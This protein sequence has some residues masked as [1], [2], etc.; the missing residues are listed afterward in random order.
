MF[1]AWGRLLATNARLV[2]IVAILTLVAAVTAMVTVAPNLSS[3]GF[4]SGDAES[5]RVDETLAATFGQTSDAVVFLF[6]A[7]QPVTDPGVQQE[8]DTSLA[9]LQGDSRFTAILTT[10]STGNPRMI[11]ESGT[12]TYAVAPLAPGVTL[13]GADFEAV[14]D[15]VTNAAAA[16]GLTVST[17][18]G[19]A[20]GSAIGKEVEQGLVRAETFSIPVTLLIQVVVFGSLI[21]AGIP[22]LIAALAILLSIAVIFT[23]S[24]DVFQS[25]FAVNIITMLGL[26]LGI[27]Y[28]LFMV[29]RFREEIAR[30]PVVEAVQVTMATVGKA[31]LV[32]GITVMVGL[33]A[34]QFFPLPALQSMG[35]AGIAAT[36]GA[37]LYGLTLLPAILALLGKRVN[38]LSIGRGRAQ[39]SGEESAF[40]HRIASGVMRYPVQ[41]AAV[42]L[43]ALLVMATPLLRLDLTPGGPDVL[44]VGDQPRT[45]SER[46]ASDFVSS[47]ADPIPVLVTID[48]GN[49]TSPAAVATLQDLTSRLATIPN[50]SGVE[51]YVSPDLATAN[52]F[53]WASWN[54]DNASL[55]AAIRAS[56]DTTVR[57][58]QVL[59]DVMTSASG[60]SLEQVVRDI[61]AVQP[62]G[63]DVTVGGSAAASV[64]TIEGI[65]SGLIPAAIFVLLGSYLILLLT[66]GSILLPIKAIFTTLLSISAALGAVVFIFQDGRLEGLLGF[67]AS[68]EI[69]S[70]TP[71]LIFCI[72]FGLS[73]DY[74][75]LMLSR[76]QEEYRRTGD[77]RASVAT[78]LARSGR[79]ITGAALI[80]VVVFGGFMLADI[81][82][83]K[84][85]GFGLALAVLIDATVVRG[86]LVPATMR[87]MGRWAWWAPTP[88]RRVVDRLGLGHETPL[89][90]GAGTD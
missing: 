69:I 87:L 57:G 27:D 82:I 35:Q 6:D 41:V 75:V 19:P 31:I 18:G 48:D 44:P 16:N 67:S 36:A 43:I 63:T 14:R 64:D 12:A 34:T 68:G 8:V 81:V 33:A 10:W 55:P 76:I 50:V 5:T 79:V 37:L 72:L 4:V 47:D 71:I 3:E 83:L 52:A 11:S 22:L 85:M 28:S 40:W 66:F 21:A 61:R 32:S 70:T 49:A 15:S 78:G 74:E 42:V 58:E 86:L 51:S 60:A 56:V 62:T 25:I 39:T 20:I 13:E 2:A 54:G 53:D 65:N 7:S 59:V 80:M 9:S 89:P 1:T 88:V 46:L 38:G 23:L 29:T 30:R 26:G 24:T 45:V 84:S 17:G 77:A 73:M 90:V